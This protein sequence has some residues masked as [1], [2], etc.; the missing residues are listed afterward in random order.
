MDIRTKITVDLPLELIVALGLDNSKKLSVTYENGSLTIDSIYDS[1][2]ISA[3]EY[4][5]E[6]DYEEGYEEGCA[7]GYSDGYFQG[8]IDAKN[9]RVFNNAYPTDDD[10]SETSGKDCGI[11]C[12]Y[13]C[14]DC[15]FY[16]PANRFCTAYD[17]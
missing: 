13:D 16:N 11:D 3:E 15:G 1:E 5:Y 4:N 8:Y 14:Y 7:E 10:E 17:D 2:L 9:G 12:D 6:E